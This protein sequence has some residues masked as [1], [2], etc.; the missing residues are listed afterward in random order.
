MSTANTT[1][2]L[3]LELKAKALKRAK[4]DNL[5]ISSVIRFLLQDYAEGHLKIG[6][7]PVLTE[8]GFTPEQE[9]EILKASQEASLDIN[10][11]E[12]DNDQ[13]DKILSSS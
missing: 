13:L 1:V 12:L 4:Q 7:K 6:V 11:T 8:N 3:N 5:S 2:S 10:L 9:D